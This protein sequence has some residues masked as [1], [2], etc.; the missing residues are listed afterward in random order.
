LGQRSHTDHNLDQVTDTNP[1]DGAESFDN[2]ARATLQVIIIA[3]GGS[4]ALSVNFPTFIHVCRLWSANTWSKVMYALMDSDYYGAFL[5]SICA[6]LVLNFW[7]LNLLVAVV[8]NTF[9][10]IRAA[11]KKSAFGAD[12]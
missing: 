12:L 6:L 10:S 7:L 9:Q 11:T 3:S 5:Y 8:V 2:I 1:R 4:S